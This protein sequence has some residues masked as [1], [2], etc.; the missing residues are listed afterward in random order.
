MF[1]GR[2]WV[3]PISPC[4]EPRVTC[5]EHAAIDQL[6]RRIE[7]VGEI[8]RAAA[9]IGER[10]DRREHVLVAALAAEAG[11]HAPDRDQR[12]RRHAVALLD[13]GEQRGLR[14][15]QRT[16]AR[17]DRGGAALGEEL[18][19]RQLEAALAA[20]GGDGRAARSSSPSAPRSRWRRRPWPAP[21]RRTAASRPR[22]R[23]RPLPHCAAWACDPTSVA[24]IAKAAAVSFLP[25]VIEITFP[26]TLH[27]SLPWRTA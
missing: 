12:P 7:L 5:R 11:L 24:K 13:R 26:A 10:C 19:E 2:N 16:P 22:S 6:Q 9:V 23:R 25:L 3:W 17:D 8:F 14:L 4:I 27:D 21:R 15:L 18:V 20:I 1:F